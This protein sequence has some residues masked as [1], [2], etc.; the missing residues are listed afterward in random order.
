MIQ[1]TII[2]G[3]F[4]TAYLMVIAIAVLFII[5]Q[6]IKMNRDKKRRK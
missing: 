1:N 4:V 3:Y 2:E 6:S 5:M